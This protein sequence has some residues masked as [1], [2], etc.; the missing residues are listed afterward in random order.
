MSNRKKI[1]RMYHVRFT[2]DFLVPALSRRDALD[3]AEDAM[4]NLIEDEDCDLGD[5]FAVT[6]ESDK[7]HIVEEIVDENGDDDE[8]TGEENGDEEVDDDEEDDEEDDDEEES[9]D[10]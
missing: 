4:I 1:K 2:S 3:L 8:D 6:V 9:D 7:F 5:L 10:T